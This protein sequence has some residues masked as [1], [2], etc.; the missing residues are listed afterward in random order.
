MNKEFLL[1]YLNT[2]SPSTFEVEG[3]KIWL[4]EMTPFADE[5]IK[6]NYGNVAVVIKGTQKKS[7]YKVVIDA[8][9]DEIGWVV[10]N[11]TDDGFI[12][13]QRNGGTDNDITQGTAVKILTEKGKIKG[14]FGSPAIHLKDSNSKEKIK[15]ENLAVDVGALTKEEVEKLGIEIGSFIVVDR[16]CE[17]MNGKFIV[18]KSLDDKIGGFIHYEVIKNL[19][20]NK[21]KLPYDLYIVNSV[22]EEVGLRGARMMNE[23][24][25]PNVAIA[26]DVTFDTNTPGINKDKHGDFKMG[27]GIVL[28]Q[29]F[30]VQHNFLKLLKDVATEN[31]IKYKIQVGGSGGTNTFSYYQNGAVTSTLSIPLR[32]M[33]TQNEM[34]ML[35][36]IQSAIDFYI[37]ALQK[38][39]NKH[40]FKYF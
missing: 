24:I 25:K 18:G 13:V 9:A 21:I 11:I 1:K 20:E 2:D 30:D 15:Q 38:I 3:Q 4:K 26:F 37:F 40:N 10:K 34:V 17:I 8:H 6:D 19:K 31:D 23:T 16:V 7:K 36:D 33:H 35:D 5:I 29:G 32:Y 27:D 28:R 39:E 22:Q 14:F 12:K